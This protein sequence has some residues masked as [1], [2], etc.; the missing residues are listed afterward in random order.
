V[1]FFA[2]FVLSEAEGLRM[3]RLKGRIMKCTNVK[4][5]SL[6][7]IGL[8]LGISLLCSMLGIAVRYSLLRV[9]VEPKPSSDVIVVLAGDAAR[10]R[11]A[12]ALVAQG[13]APRVLST[14][15]DPQCVRAGQP[16]QVCASG[17]RNTVDEA[18][19]AACSQSSSASKSWVMVLKVCTSFRTWSSGVVIS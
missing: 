7:Q 8:L 16:P 5:S 13:V 11:Y 19:P 3:I 1:S 10:D 18:Q 4:Y 6:E 15:V 14:L 9:R 12:T 17:V 2:E